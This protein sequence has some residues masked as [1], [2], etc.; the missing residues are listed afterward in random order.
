ME[1][2]ELPSHTRRLELGFF[3]VEQIIA[4]NHRGLIIT[5]GKN[6]LAKSKLDVL[7]MYLRHSEELTETFLW[8]HT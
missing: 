8:A 6:N 1:R 7:K 3:P 2:P 4:V 5:Q